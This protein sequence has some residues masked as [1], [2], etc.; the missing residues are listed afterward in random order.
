[1][2]RG[3]KI[4][5]CLTEG[6]L[7][8][9][10]LIIS[11]SQAHLTPHLHP[12]H[13]CPAV[14]SRPLLSSCCWSPFSFLRA[15]CSPTPTQ[16]SSLTTATT[17]PLLLMTLISSLL[18]FYISYFSAKNKR[19]SFIGASLSSLHHHMSG[20]STCSS[21]VI[22]PSRSP[23]PKPPP[24]PFPFVLLLES[25]VPRRLF[26]TQQIYSCIFYTHVAINMKF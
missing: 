15:Y 18:H 14:Q 9:H 19:S 5:P 24:E 12:A 4:T 23:R 26:S 1:M 11:P 20:F 21:L 6:T 2:H 10:N 16:M 17:S 3:N 25:E 8:P 22:L 7:R 13:S